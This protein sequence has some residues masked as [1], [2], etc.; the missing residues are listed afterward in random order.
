MDLSQKITLPHELVSRSKT[1]A[2]QVVSDYANGRNAASRAV[3]C[4]DAHSNVE[5]QAHAKMAECAFALWCGA[6]PKYA[7]QWERFCDDG[8]DFIFNGW[9]WDVKATKGNGKFLIWPIAKN[10][11]FASKRFDM[12]VL[13]RGD[14]P[15]FEIVGCVTKGGFANRKQIA[16]QGHKLFRGT[17]YMNAA[18]LCPMSWLEDARYDAQD[19]FARSLDVGYAAI[20]ERKANGGPG[21]GRK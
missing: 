13:V 6:D 19:D 1:W 17:W 18:D 12:L 21:W 2:E 4:F 11:I 9:R 20:R 3:T 8:A 14:V 5:L 10:E 15:N 7:I 16:T